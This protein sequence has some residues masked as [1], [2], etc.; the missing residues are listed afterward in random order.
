MIHHPLSPFKGAHYPYPVESIDVYATL[1]ELLK[2]PITREKACAGYKCKQ[3]QGKSLVPTI[4]GKQLYEENFGSHNFGLLYRLGNIFHPM[5][6]DQA[7]TIMP[8]LEHNFALSQVMRCAVKSK[9][10]SRKSVGKSSGKGEG[11][12]RTS[13]T[14][15]WTDCDAEKHNPRE[16]VLLGYAM[17]TPEYRY[18]AYFNFNRTT[19]KP[20]LDFL[21]YAEE[22][23]DHKN[24]TLS[25][26]THRETFNLAIKPVYGLIIQSLRNK[27]VNF[28]RTSIPFGDH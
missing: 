17:R 2:L 12:S 20:E 15:I 21:P 19:Q 3:L 23:Y 7:D 27:L 9:I 5:Q 16:V 28:I 18:I 11:S 8:M 14:A 24:E 13:R 25:D 6:R 22:L 1:N 26:F 10:P 4:L